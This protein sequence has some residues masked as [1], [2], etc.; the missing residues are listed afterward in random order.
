MMKKLSWILLITIVLLISVGGF[1]CLTNKPVK[2][3]FVGGLTG[4]FSDIGISGRNGVTLAVEEANAAG[5]IRGKSI[6]VVAK[7]DHGDTNAVIA[8]D[9]ELVAEGV[10]VIIGHMTSAASVAAMPFLNS[11]EAQGILMI[12]PTTRTSKLT[13]L[14]DNFFA[15]MP[16]L[17]T[18]TKVQA[19][20]VTK[21]GIKKMVILYDLA[22]RAFAEDWDTNF[23]VTYSALGGE[24]IG[25][26]SFQS[27]TT[28]SYLQMMQDIAQMQPDG[29][30]LI[31][32]GVDAAMFCQQ[33]PKVGLR[34]LIF[35]SSWAMTDEFLQ[36]GGPAVE[37]VVF[38]NPVNPENHYP[39][40]DRFVQQYQAR[41]G[42]KPD[43]AA[44]YS[45]EAAVV[46]I[47]GLRANPDVRQLKQSILSQKTF[48]GLWGTFDFN[49]FGDAVRG[50]LI[51]SV[52]NGR[53]KM[54]E[55][56]E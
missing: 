30:L 42:K 3:G 24:I 14:D 19:D 13:G 36:Q 4:R 49:A 9:R 54:V 43:Y 28:F 16:P 56:Y 34:A 45:H 47:E 40:Y 44:A 22:N 46:A 37:G 33:I 35:S 6:E 15:I 26:R 51:L 31:A 2:I 53:F 11:P 27:G 12:S 23:S 17:K 50:N 21:I 52:Q 18:A 10:A 5:G 20:Y 7:D 48:A 25:R 38:C 8:V 41:F 32:S 1:G 55:G 39:Q 29:V